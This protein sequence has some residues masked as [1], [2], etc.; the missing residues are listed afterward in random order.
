MDKLR[1]LFVTHA[2]WRNDTSI[3]NSYSNIFAEMDDRIEFAQIYIR[4]GEPENSLVNRYFHIPE[5]ELLKSI[6]TRNDVGHSV[7][8]EDSFNTKT[9]EFSNTYNKIRSLRWDVFL[10]ARDITTVLGKWKTSELDIFI[11]EFNPDIIFGAFS[12]MPIINELM[13]YVKNRSKAKLVLYPWDDWFN[14]H[15]STKDPFYYIRV[16]IE[17]HYMSKTVKACDFMYVITEQMKVEYNKLFGKECKVLTKGFSDE[18]LPEIK[19]DVNSPIEIV[20]AGNIGDNRWE[21]LA[22]IA[23][24]IDYV[25]K[26]YDEI[27]YNMTIY[28]MTPITTEIKEGLQIKGASEIKGAV[29]S[30]VVQRLLSQADIAVHVEPTEKEKIE[31]CRLSFSTKLV[32]YFFHGNCILAVGGDN[33]SM[34]YLKKN[35]AALV[36]NN[37]A[38]ITESLIYLYENQNKIIE[39]RQKARKCG[40]KNHNIKKLQNMIIEDFSYLVN[41]GDK[42]D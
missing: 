10:L 32:D 21:I 22:E 4:K 11:D 41:G 3:G 12:F 30:K 15:F 9:T 8:Y 20:Y 17:R 31:N 14:Y 29:S 13:L 38:K 28:T 33:A 42:D 19:K 35:D 16:F 34:K 7:F 36:I 40:I 39:L 23:K 37:L 6:I 27:I 5:N 18:N 26:K 2:P 25:N 1:V 24:S